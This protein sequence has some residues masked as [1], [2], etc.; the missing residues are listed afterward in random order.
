MWRGDFDV[1]LEV[2]VADAERRFSL[3]LRGLHRVRQL[4]GR[5]HDPHAASAA[6][7]RRLDDDRIAD[8]LGDLERLLL[9]LD[10]SVAAGQDG[11]AGLLHHAARPR[12]VAHQANHLRVGSDEPDVAR[13][14]HLRE[15]GAFRE[16]PVSRVDGVG[17]G[18][19][20][21]GDHSRHVQVAVGAPRRAD[22]DVLV[23]EAAMQASSRRLRR[24]RRRS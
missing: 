4:A 15:V 11:E 13:L 24:T 19:F 20:R 6:A 10:R 17:A 7:G 22:A 1:L 14:A 12:L 18:D 8:V 9:A 5:A 3:A 23:G 2:D 16:K 21:R